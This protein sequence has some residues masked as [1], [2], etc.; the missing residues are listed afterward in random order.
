MIR[1]RTMHGRVFPPAPSMFLP[2]ARP[3]PARCARLPAAP[4]AAIDGKLKR[5]AIAGGEDVGRWCKLAST[6][7]LSIAS[8]ASR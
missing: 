2:R 7:M 6:A 8:P 3:A 5:A 4:R 1:P